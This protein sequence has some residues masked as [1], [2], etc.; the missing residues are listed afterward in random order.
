ML[1]NVS[2][3]SCHSNVFKD[4]KPVL[5]FDKYNNVIKEILQPLIQFAAIHYGEFISLVTF[6]NPGY[7]MTIGKKV[8]GD[9]TLRF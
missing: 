8:N 3:Y 5:E 4:D 6:N 9:I 1:A 7:K 2:F